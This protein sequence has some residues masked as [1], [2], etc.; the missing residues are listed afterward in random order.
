MQSRQE[1][2]LHFHLNIPAQKKNN[3]SGLQSMN[4][5]YRCQQIFNYYTPMSDYNMEMGHVSH[6][7]NK[8]ILVN[9]SIVLCLNGKKKKKKRGDL[10]DTAALVLPFLCFTLR[11]LMWYASIL[12]VL[13]K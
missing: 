1:N 3:I 2:L 6:C 9:S 7:D 5:E 4:N 13:K 8:E 11:L 10:Y 12:L